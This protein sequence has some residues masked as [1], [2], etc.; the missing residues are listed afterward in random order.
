MEAELS[1][2]KARV[3]DLTAQLN[4]MTAEIE[5]TAH[6]AAQKAIQERLM[7]GD[8]GTFHDPR[9]IVGSS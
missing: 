4:D 1:N 5:S 7:S 2:E 8:G 3:L 6:K 9:K